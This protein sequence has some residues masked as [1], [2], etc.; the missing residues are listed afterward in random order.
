MTQANSSVL[1][2]FRPHDHQS[3]ISGVMAEAEEV[4]RVA[5]ARLTPVR[6]RVLEILLEE[7]RPMGAYDVLA[8]LDAEG[9]GDKPPVAYR[10]LGFLSDHGLVHRIERLNAFIAC[11]HPASQGHSAAFL[12]CRNCRLVAEV[13]AALPE[14]PNGFRIERTTMEAEGLCAGC[15]AG[16]AA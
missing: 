14:I 9:L 13:P 2:E 16:G 10:A 12:I 7:H 8:R 11:R 3:C 6:R 4:C 15:I 5:G 1:R